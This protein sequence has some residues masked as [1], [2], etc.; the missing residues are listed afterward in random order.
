MHAA[1]FAAKHPIALNVFFKCTLVFSL[2]MK[3][4]GEIRYVC[5]QANTATPL[6]YCKC[7]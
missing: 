7:V 3:R 6:L 2:K 1:D 4:A 5:T